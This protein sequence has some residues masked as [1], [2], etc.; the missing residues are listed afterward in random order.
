MTNNDD[1]SDGDSSG[2]GAASIGWTD[3]SCHVQVTVERAETIFAARAAV[4]DTMGRVGRAIDRFDPQSELSR[5]NRRAGLMTPVSPLCEELVGEALDAARLTRGGCDPT[6]GIPLLSAGYDRDIDEIRTDTTGSALRDAA[7]PSAPPRLPGWRQVRCNHA[8]N[9]IGVPQGV[10]LDLG[11]T[12]KAWTAQRCAREIADRYDTAAL[13][14]I[15]G[16]VA[17]GGT[18]SRAWRVAVSERPGEHEQLIAFEQGAVATSTST[19]RT[20]IQDGTAAHHIIDPRTGLPSTGPWR[21]A[22]VWAA[23]AV[24]ANAISTAVIACGDEAESLLARTHAP[25]RLVDNDGN[26][27]LVGDWPL[28]G[29]HPETNTASTERHGRAVA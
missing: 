25:A 10:A 12:A 19:L 21:S 2:R 28:E 22:S 29:A 1:G 20:W 14:S 5:I 17:A 9:L 26:V 24:R 13:V 8:W 4:M 7:P 16:D 3:W 27:T 18:P 6:L 15:G 23:D 11:A